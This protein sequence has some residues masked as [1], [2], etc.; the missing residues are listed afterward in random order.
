MT[1]TPAATATARLTGWMVNVLLAAVTL[2][3]AAYLV[4]SLLGYERY[5]ITGGSMSGS[6]E[7]GSIVFEKPVDV[8]ELAVGDVVTYLPPPESGVGTLVTH[9]IVDAKRGRSGSRVFVTQGD[10]NPDPDPWKF[11]LDQGSQP[12]VQLAVPYAGYALIALADRET[13][14]L[15]IGLPAAL[16]AL[17][18][19]LELV[20]ALRRDD[21]H[22]DAIVM[23]EVPADVHPPVQ[24]PG[25]V[26]P[27]A[28]TAADTS[29][30]S[31]DAPA[32]AAVDSSSAAA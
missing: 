14:M 6:I 21:E 10:A 18:A 9:R 19:L 1:S 27:S 2:V 11:T 31:A 7:K 5:V 13:R 26:I 4:P 3:A 16:I 32:L 8:A 30:A 29:P 24:R 17:L 22:A 28:R 20:G 15:V 23:T 12:V 25:L